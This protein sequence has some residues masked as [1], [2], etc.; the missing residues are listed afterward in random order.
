VK[1]VPS[2]YLLKGP[3][4]MFLRAGSSSAL[5][6]LSGEPSRSRGT[7]GAQKSGRGTPRAH[8]NLESQI[9]ERTAEL[10]KQVE[11]RS[12]IE[13]ALLKYNERLEILS[14]TAGQLLVSDKPQQLV[15]ELCRK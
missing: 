4:I 3:R 2:K 1:I 12:R 15:E 6:R 9:E 14:Y 8:R 7:A 13:A 11:H 10:K 5:C